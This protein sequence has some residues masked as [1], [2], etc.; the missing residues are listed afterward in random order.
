MLEENIF[1]NDVVTRAKEILSN[2]RGSTG[3]YSESV[4]IPIIRKH[5]AEFI[6][7]RDG[8]PSNVNDIIVTN[9]ASSAVKVITFYLNW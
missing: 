7:K 8:Y 3:C 5:I 6:S 2:I 4:G 1:P 9:G